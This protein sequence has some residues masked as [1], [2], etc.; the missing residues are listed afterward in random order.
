[1]SQANQ[2]HWAFLIDED[3]PRSLALVLRT[4]SYD[5]IDVRDVGLRG[6]DDAHLF[7]YA[8][9]HQRTLITEDLGFANI[10]QFP[11]GTHAG[12]IVCRFPN[13][14]PTPAVNQKILDA[15]S[16]LTGKTL[17]GILIIVEPG[18]IRVRNK[19]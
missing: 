5:A 7:A 13:S 19:P 9:T 3:M 2:P 17:V 12:I 14:V 11:L 10:I 6:R 16:A 8:Q 4:N 15:L 18:K 1:M